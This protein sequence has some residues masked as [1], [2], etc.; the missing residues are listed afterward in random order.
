[1]AFGVIFEPRW[2]IFRAPEEEPTFQPF[3]DW[4][5]VEL[6]AGI[7]DRDAHDKEQH[8]HHGSV[9]RGDFVVRYPR[10][11]EVDQWVVCDV[12]RIGDV[13][14]EFA[15]PG[16]KPSGDA[17]AC[18]HGDDDREG[19]DDAEGFVQ[20]IHPEM[21]GAADSGEG[22]NGDDQEAADK[23][24]FLYVN[25]LPP[26]HEQNASEEGIEQA[27]E[28][29]VELRLVYAPSA[30]DIASGAH[31]G[32][33]NEQTCREEDE[34]GEGFVGELAKADSVEN[35]RDVLKE[36]RPCG[37]V[38][39]MHLIPS[40]DVHGGKQGDHGK[41]NEH[42]D[43][44]L[45]DGRCRDQ[46][47]YGSGLEVEEGR[48]DDGAHDDHWLEADE[49][50]F[51]ELPLRHLSP[52]VIVGIGDDEAGQKEEEID[53]QVSVIDDL[54]QGV[55]V[56]IRFEGVEDHDRQSGH[57]A[58]AIEYLVMALGLEVRRSSVH[59]VL[60]RI[61]WPAELPVGLHKAALPLAGRIGFGR[62]WN[63]PGMK[64]GGRERI[65]V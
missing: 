21:V 41:S 57:A 54:L 30:D 51:V 5:I 25:S 28:A 15:E 12:E 43:Q 1:M 4:L 16:G 39:R 59:V 11:V 44:H 55:I 60:T 45:P 2:S 3:S 65:S 61:H 13:P 34:Y 9:G 58:Q 50:S 33:M 7:R 26:T 62:A 36:E 22:K 18:A 29:D 47:K 37:T 40:T 63:H 32:E 64:C 23:E 46:G 38:Q 52:A 8:A 48:S 24:C 17:I 14:E 20:A 56:G 6:E 27:S 53:C 35:I 49:A 19:N 42:H 10:G 31:Y